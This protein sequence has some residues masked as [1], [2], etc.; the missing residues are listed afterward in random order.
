MNSCIYTGRMGHIRRSPG[1]HR[2]S[3][4]MFML[5][6]D[7]DELHSVFK[8]N[9][10]WS[11][12]RSNLASFNESDHYNDKGQ[13]LADSIRSLIRR[14]TG[15]EHTGSI[16]LLTHLR[17]FG[18]I[19]NPVSFYYCHG[20]DGDTLDF[21]V[22]EVHNTP[23]GER[24]CYVLDCSEQR[25]SHEKSFEFNKEFHVSPFMAM[26]QAYRWRFNDPGSELRVI[27]TN[28]EQGEDIFTA[29]SHM[30]R[31]PLTSAGLNRMLLSYPAMTLQVI[32]AIYWQAL[33]LWLKNIPFHAHPKHF[34]KRGIHS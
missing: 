13:G 20:P 29:W 32:T 25:D 27:M 11:V 34:L 2:F 5:Y 24:H 22:A 9:R 23:W 18:F 4:R 31:Q 1:I 6:L 28:S 26:K 33:R 7:L 3:Y 15:K 30:Q 16:R 19:M 14:E 8:H 17:Y 10:L 21:I 12:N